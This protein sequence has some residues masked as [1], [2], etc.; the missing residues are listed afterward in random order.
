[1]EAYSISNKFKFRYFNKKIII[2]IPARGLDKHFLY[3]LVPLLDKI[4]NN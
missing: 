4:E 1:M 3:Y 2:T